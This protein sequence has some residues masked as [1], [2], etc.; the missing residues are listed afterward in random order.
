MNRF[1]RIISILSLIF[2]AFFLSFLILLWLIPQRSSARVF[3]SPSGC[4]SGCGGGPGGFSLEEQSFGS[5]GIKYEWPEQMNLNS[6]DSISIEVAPI[7][8]GT[9]VERPN[10]TPGGNYQ[11]VVATPPFFEGTPYVQVNGTQIPTTIAQIYGPGYQVSAYAQLLTNTFDIKTFQPPEQ[12]L[13]QSVLSWAWNVKPTS[14]GRQVINLD[15]DF[16]WR[17]VGKGQVIERQI[18]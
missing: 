15:V 8:S 5:I 13:K 3:L 1:V 10:P 12:P 7:N 11:V 17:P 2:I 4:S 18:W 14:L 9:M 16:L 6:S